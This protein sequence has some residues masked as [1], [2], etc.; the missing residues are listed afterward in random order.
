L[1]SDAVINLAVKALVYADHGNPGQPVNVGYAV[2]TVAPFG[3]GFGWL[4]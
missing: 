3:Q 1:N 4:M 2:E